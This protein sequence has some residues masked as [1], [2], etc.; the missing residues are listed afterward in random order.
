MCHEA[1]HDHGLKL[2]ALDDIPANVEY[3]RFAHRLDFFARS[4]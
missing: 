3:H 4:A 1:I 2:I